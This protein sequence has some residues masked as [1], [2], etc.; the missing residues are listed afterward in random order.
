MVLAVKNLPANVGDARDVGSTPGS[1]RSLE[2]E[3]WQPTP[4]FL[5]GKSHGQGSLAGYSS[6]GC[7]RVGQDLVTKQQ[8]INNCRTIN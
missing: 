4:V 6:W 5:L 7:K 1:G 3:K 8:I 2:E